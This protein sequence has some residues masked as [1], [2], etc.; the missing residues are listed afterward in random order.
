MTICIENSG[1]N[2][3][4]QVSIG[5]GECS[6]SRQTYASQFRFNIFAPVTLGIG[7]VLI[8]EFGQ[9]V[10]SR[11]DILIL[12]VEVS[13]TERAPRHIRDWARTSEHDDEIGCRP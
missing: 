9:L 10:H 12:V 1:L 8:K 5:A 7:Q 6:P 13:G 4:E 11:G 3:C 2:F